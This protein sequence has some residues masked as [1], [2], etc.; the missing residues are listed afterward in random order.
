MRAL[1]HHAGELQNRRPGRLPREGIRRCQPKDL[2]A[3]ANH[4]VGVERQ[5]AREFRADLHAGD[6]LPNDE[7]SRGADADGIKAQRLCQYAGTE[8]LVPAYVDASEK[9]D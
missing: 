6:G 8:R 5:Q 2:T 7:G 3:V 1:R 4:D 9:D